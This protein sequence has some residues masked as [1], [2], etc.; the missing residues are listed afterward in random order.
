MEIIADKKPPN[1][2]YKKAAFMSLGAITLTAALATIIV[3]PPVVK[4]N[5]TNAPKLKE[6]SRHA[7]LINQ[8]VKV[9]NKLTNEHR[10]PKLSPNDNILKE[11]QKVVKKII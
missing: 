11:V 1:P 7:V 6:P 2:S 3:L 4:D 10:Y 8:I 5:K 9:R